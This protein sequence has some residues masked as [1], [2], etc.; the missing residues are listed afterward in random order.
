MCLLDDPCAPAGRTIDAPIPQDAEP[1]V[2]TEADGTVVQR[3]TTT[4]GL[5]RI[6]AADGSYFTWHNRSAAVPGR[7]IQPQV[8]KLIDLPG[9]PPSRGAVLFSATYDT[10]ANWDPLIARP[11]TDTVLPEPDY[12]QPGWWPT[13][14]FTVNTLKTKDGFDEQIVMTPG[15]FSLPG[16]QRRYNSFEFN[17]YHSDNADRQWPSVWWTDAAYRP[18]GVDV[19]VDTEDP[20]GIRRVLATYTDGGG[21]WRSIDLARGGDDLYR[22]AIATAQPEAIRYFIQSVD[23]AGNVAVYTDKQDYFRAL[24]PRLYLP[25]VLQRSTFPPTTAPTPTPT[26][27]AGPPSARITEIALSGSQYVVEFTTTSFTPQLPGVHLHFFFNTVPPNQAGVPGA[28]PWKIHG[29]SAPFTEYGFADR[30]A[31][32]TQMCVLVANADH[33]VRLGTG[34]CFDLPP[35]REYAEIVGIGV[36]G[37]RY[38]VH[39]R[40]LGYTPVLPGLH[41]H[42]FFDTVPPSQAGVP[43][44]GPWRVY[45]GPTP[46][47]GY[48]LTDRPVGARKICVLVANPN[49]SVRLDTGN[50][51]DL[52]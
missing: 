36:A 33:T 18:N 46:Y 40:T 5:T 22:G 28:G 31:A 10:F 14:F 25:L 20:S 35:I 38:A 48:L 49:H 43:G 9:V 39:F 3:F 24:R 13:H 27:T 11:I 41:V 16:T 51:W 42:F 17:V 52:P 45:G 19:V 7:P 21:Q 4:T 32:A 44:Y 6:D 47:T 2:W 30:P 50:C 15:K 1:E 12:V 23:N 26:P 34:N 29:S 37:N 8:A